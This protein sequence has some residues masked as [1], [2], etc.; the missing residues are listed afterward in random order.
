MRWLA[1]SSALIG[2]TVET[3]REHEVLRAAV[4]EELATELD[5]PEDSTLAELISAVD[6]PVDMILSDLAEV[7]RASTA[8]V[9]LLVR[10]NDELL[11]SLIGPDHKQHVAEHSP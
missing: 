8:E 9:D 10:G 11:L 3:L 1:A 5:L 4:T 2:Q 6:S 7:L